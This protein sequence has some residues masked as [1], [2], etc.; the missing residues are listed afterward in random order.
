MAD[1]LLINPPVRENDLPRN[2][3][4]GL[5]IIAACLRNEGYK[6][7][8]LDVNGLRI[9]IECL[10][11]WLEMKLLASDA[12]VIGIG[13]MI[14]TYRWVKDLVYW[15]KKVKPDVKIVIGGSL[16]SSIPDIV[17]GWPI[18]AICRGD[19]EVFIS[20]YLED[21]DK[22]KNLVFTTVKNIYIDNLD[23][24]PYPAWD[25]FPMDNYLA[26]PIVGIGRD[27]DVI[28]SRG[29]PFKCN[30]CV[31]GE[32]LIL[33]ADGSSV[34]IEGVSV[35]DKIIGVKTDSQTGRLKYCETKVRD[36]WQTTKP[37]VRI[38]MEN[39]TKLICSPDHR[40]LTASRGWKY[41]TGAMGGPKQRPYLTTNSKMRG[42]GCLNITPV[43]TDNYKKGYL[44]GM[45][46]GDGC[47][48]IYNAYDKR[49]GGIYKH[50]FFRLATIDEECIKRAATY[51]EYFGVEVHKFKMKSRGT[52]RNLFAIRR[53]T[54]GV[55][56]K[57]TEL[58]KHI[59]N[60]EF[61]RGYLAGIY[62][63]EGNLD[64]STIRIAN[65]DIKILRYISKC[66]NSHKFSSRL[67]PYF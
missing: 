1:I 36:K 46:E 35:G 59:S 40:W 32:T 38:T 31:S 51:L 63:A 10:S 18:D 3:P 26:N 7:E 47:L 53:T 61:Y 28:S 64:K 37:A 45:I 57:I 25:L 56:Y 12:P 21:A 13:G 29:C 52:Y 15:L 6:V 44:A 20:S 41:T 23:D 60:L 5:G 17:A 2:F 43:I 62:D 9:N 39:G 58:I 34:P 48:Q 66:L 54:R 42:M 65:K 14:T 67:L 50:Y 11:P 30:F 8:V 22:Y 49:N 24:L 33:M 16:A 27:M 55:F 4:T 19:G